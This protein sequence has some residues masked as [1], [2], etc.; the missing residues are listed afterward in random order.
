VRAARSPGDARPWTYAALFGAL[1][2][3][4][5]LTLGT[6]LHLA[7]LPAGQVL[8]VLGLVCLVTLRRLQPRAGVCLLAGAVA[9]FLKVFAVGG[10]RLGPL[11]GIGAEA[12]LVEAAFLVGRTTVA[13]AVAGGALVLTFSAVMKVVVVWLV[14]GREALRG[15]LEAVRI[16]LEPFELAGLS[17]AVV[18]AAI[19][20][21]HAVLGAAAGLWAW[22]VAGRVL[23]RLGRPT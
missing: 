3:A 18:L 16:L 4:L 1:W 19:L 6:T 2:G 15:Y 23:R 22:I 17:G 10:L 7:Q 21:A 14:A 8:G 20:A 12:V 13:A 5:E 11:V 9:V